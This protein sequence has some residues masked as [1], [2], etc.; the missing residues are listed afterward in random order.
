[1][2]KDIIDSAQNK[3]ANPFYKQRHTQP[4]TVV[5]IFQPLYKHMGILLELLSSH[6]ALIRLLTFEAFV[7]S[8][9]TL[10]TT[11]FQTIPLS[12]QQSFLFLLELLSSN[13][14]PVFQPKNAFCSTNHT[15]SDQAYT[16]PQ[17]LSKGT[18]VSK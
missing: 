15:R 1:M 7:F 4:K 16:H 13:I 8:R 12:T 18:Q 5:F 2:G 10:L 11:P 9:V 6:V 14:A 17:G 3:P